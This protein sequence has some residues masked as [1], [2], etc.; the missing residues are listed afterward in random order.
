MKF[1]RN[2][3][4]LIGIL[5]ILFGIQF[6]LVDSFVLNERCTKALDRVMR[7]TPVA[8]NDPFSSFVMQVHPNPTKRVRPPRWIGAAMV[9]SGIVISLHSFSL[10]RH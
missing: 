3:Y 10:R 2:H 6:R 5:L 9:V 7:N 8:S 4:F 1:T